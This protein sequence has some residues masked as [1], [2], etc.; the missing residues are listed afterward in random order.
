ME[1]FLTPASISYITQTIIFLG[2]TV[3][4]ILKNNGT[5]ANFWLSSAYSIMVAAGLAGFIGVSS[6]QV[7]AEGMLIHDTLLVLGLA[8]LTQFAYN[9]STIKSVGGKQ[10]KLILWFNN[11]LTILA[12]LFSINYLF[13]F[14]DFVYFEYTSLFVKIFLF[15]EITWLMV[16]FVSLTTR[17]ST[18]ESKKS[19]LSRFMHPEGR[20]A[21]AARGF[22]YSII[23]LWIF[24][25]AS[26]VLSLYGQSNLAMFIFTLV[27][28][29][30][31]TFFIIALVD[32]TIRKA[33]FYFKFILIILLTTFTGISAST[34][35]TAPANTANYLAMFSFPNL[36][37]IQFE[38]NNAVYDITNEKYDFD[39]NLGDKVVF[40]DGELSA[41]QDL[42]FTFPFAGINW[43]T[44]QINKTGSVIFNKDQ[45]DIDN[46][47]LTRNKYPLITTLYVQDLV[48]SENSSVFVKSTYDKMVITWFVTSDEAQNNISIN[49]QLVLLPDGS[50]KISYNDVHVNVTYNPYIPTTLNQV[51]GFFLGSNDQY[52][53]RLNFSTQLP[54]TS[55]NWK[56]VYQDFY[57]DF[58]NHLHWSISIQ[59][60]AM[61][62]VTGLMLLLYPFLINSSLVKPIQVIRTAIANVTKGE[63]TNL[64]EP[65]YSDD[66]GQTTFEFNQMARIL[67]EKQQN[68]EQKLMNME[69]K[70]TIRTIELK[71]TV[72]RLA[73][74]I[75]NRKKLRNNLDKVIQQNRILEVMDELGCFNRSQVITLLEHEM[76][77]A[78]RYNS[79]LSFVVVDPDYLRMINETYGFA[80]GNEVLKWLI[81]L[82]NINLRETDILGRIGGEEFSIIMPETTGKDALVA[83]DRIRKLIGERPVETSKGHVRLSASMGV[84]EVTIDGFAS[85]DLVIHKANLALESA[86]S[87]GRNKVVRYNS[88]MEKES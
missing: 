12:I 78:K 21:I 73:N 8:L 19:W 23:A 30:S 42:E 47:S 48:P 31:L 88:K 57:I 63:Y 24:W 6:L 15:L 59:F 65:H 85:A 77:R 28:T 67:D 22:G 52:P 2:I 45:V 86:K 44:I 39:E 83:V 3:Y 53:T 5:K 80:T 51:S 75:N 33:S 41:I 46:F 10:A 81:D 36:R 66:L 27:T 76:N 71:Q 49:T 50:F 26:I 20:L 55:I 29:W 13:R 64:K 61:L 56:G 32:Q 14:F 7:Q 62:M 40:Q 82:L 16:F 74:E 35:I 54:I 43:K 60:I 38:Q 4:L 11:L 70:L 79:S 72:D 37:T 69:E 1:L 87:Q 18:D 17:L 25:A 34:W 9:F 84:V 68:D 58:R